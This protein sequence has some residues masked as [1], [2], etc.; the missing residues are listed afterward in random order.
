[1]KNY[2]IMPSVLIWVF[3]ITA[4]L[5]GGGC[6]EDETEPE[7]GIKGTSRAVYIA[8]ESGMRTIKIESNSA[9]TLRLSPD[10]K[11]WA[12]IEGAES[13]EQAGSV[14]IRYKTNN[15]FPRKGT[16]LVASGAQQVIDTIYLMQYGSEPL[17]QVLDADYTFS[18][19]S[20]SGS[21]RI[22]TN[23]SAAHTEEIEIDIT[24]DTSA[25]PN[26]I[27]S[28]YLSE[29]LRDLHFRVTDNLAFETRSANIN[30]HFTDAW[31][32][33]YQTA[34][35]ITQGIPGGTSETR[36][37]TFAELRG[38]IAESEGE[39]VIEND[40]AI[41]G[42]VI[43]DCD[44]KNTASNSMVKAGNRP[45]RTI[46][47]RTVYMQTPDASMGLALLTTEVDQNAMRRYDKL[48]LWCKGLTLVKR[49]NPERYQLTGVTRDHIVTKS[50]GTA[51]DVPVK[52]RF[53]DQLTDTDLYTF[54]T[55]KR[56]QIA[57]R[58]GRFMPIYE[59]YRVFHDHYPTAVIDKH[60]DQIYLMTNFDCDYHFDEMPDGEGTISG[61]IVHEKYT[62]FEK[63][64]NIGAYQ[65]RNVTREDIALNESIDNGFSAVAVEWCPD[66][67]NSG[68][69]NARDYCYPQFP[70]PSNS[71]GK[72]HG[73][74]AKIGTGY[75][76]HSSYG[77]LAWGF[78]YRKP[79]GGDFNGAW[80]HTKW[81]DD[82]SKTWQ[83]MMF[84]FSTKGLSSDKCFFTFAGRNYTGQGGLRYWAAEYSIDGDNWVKFADFTIPDQGN[85]GSMQLEQLTGDKYICLSAPT[86]ILGH[87]VAWIRLRPTQNKIG[88]STTY[89][90]GVL[91]S[92]GYTNKAFVVSY[93][94]IRY[95]K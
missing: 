4:L 59:N 17:L 42:V 45:D 22:D 88:T 90:S 18:S 19:V 28:I 8:S 75:S 2:K 48:K 23:I 7:I 29:D 51:E 66:G 92:S 25:T 83:S 34:C 61:I 27:D 94:A 46:S 89:D 33:E 6:T 3:A 73:M 20:D 68:F 50:A 65:I 78:T 47:D 12:A 39:L 76:F 52:R 40:I 54:V 1:M 74:A 36:E 49:S 71:E 31:G 70:Y 15:S 64:G 72:A 79:G 30:L 95:N 38:L 44:S 62:H 67:T 41:D 11:S 24:D 37:V 21:C 9:W 60:G 93:A 10:T 91:A 55:L 86:E 82:S 77:W 16:L 57:L 13:G 53:I 43:S 56:C 87:D 5:C 69:G 85:W 63:G 26:W 14:A 35:T 84:E 81:W 80:G 32:K 58:A